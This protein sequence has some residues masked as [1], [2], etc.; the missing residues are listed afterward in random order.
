M[1]KDAMREWARFAG[2]EVLYDQYLGEVD[3]LMQELEEEGLP[4]YG[5]TYEIRLEALRAFYPELFGEDEE[6]DFLDFF[7]APISVSWEKA[8]RE[9][10]AEI[11]PV[12]DLEP[13]EFLSDGSAYARHCKGK[14]RKMR[15]AKIRKAHKRKADKELRWIIHRSYHEIA[16]VSDRD[17]WKPE[18]FYGHRK[19]RHEARHACFKAIR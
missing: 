19:L 15:T 4:S 17:L 5:S 10:E 6:S 8:V 16:R 12:L 14:E 1:K 2:L 13:E 11:E 9:H 7:P 18:R 3:D